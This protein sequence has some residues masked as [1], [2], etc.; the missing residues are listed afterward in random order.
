METVLSP[1]KYTTIDCPQKPNAEA[2]AYFLVGTKSKFGC[3]ACLYTHT[4]ACAH[5]HTI[6]KSWLQVP[7]FEVLHS[8]MAFAI[9]WD[10]FSEED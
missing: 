4:H 2:L 3:E 7:L 9:G 8:A 5:T 6:C 1:L 10:Q